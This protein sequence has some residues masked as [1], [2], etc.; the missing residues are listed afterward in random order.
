MPSAKSSHKRWR[1]RPL[2]KEISGHAGSIPIPGGH[3]FTTVPVLI[4]LVSFSFELRV[5]V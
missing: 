3:G 5:Y 4:F 1:S 2:G